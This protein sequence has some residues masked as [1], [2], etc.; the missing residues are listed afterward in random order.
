MSTILNE[1]LEAYP[2]DSFLTADGFSDAVIGLDEQS[3]R[4]VYSVSKCIAILK[5]EGMTEEDALEHFSFNVS[6]AYVGEQT[7]IWCNDS[8][9]LST[10]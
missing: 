4:L 7:P 9:D 5:E 1:I 8:Y 6:G 2:D 10:F 3:M